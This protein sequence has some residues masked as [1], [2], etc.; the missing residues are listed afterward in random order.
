MAVPCNPKLEAHSQELREHWK[1]VDTV[2]AGGALCRRSH[3][4]LADTR[5]GDLS[6]VY[7][8]CLW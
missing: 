5:Q 3:A 1:F 6:P 7:F 4:K 8:Q 2:A